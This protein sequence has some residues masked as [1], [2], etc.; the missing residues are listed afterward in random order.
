M[1]VQE[2]RLRKQDR[3]GHRRE[4]GM[5][6]TERDVSMKTHQTFMSLLSTELLTL[7]LLSL[8]GCDYWP[9]PL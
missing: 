5:I 9:P 1:G 4:F 6:P 3:I 8:N 7:G 2:T